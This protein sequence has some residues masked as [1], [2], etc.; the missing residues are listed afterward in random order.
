MYDTLRNR[1]WF[2]KV[3]EVVL[4]TDDRTTINYEITGGPERTLFV[5]SILT[6]IM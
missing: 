2:I 3:H 4:K 6:I 1:A 5:M